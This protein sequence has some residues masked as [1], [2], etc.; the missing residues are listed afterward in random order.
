MQAIM[1]SITGT[2]K[3]REEKGKGIT[4]AP[5]TQQQRKHNVNVAEE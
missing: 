5:L 3:E 4:F 2:G 1:Q